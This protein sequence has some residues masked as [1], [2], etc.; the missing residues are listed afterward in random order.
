MPYRMVISPVFVLIQGCRHGRGYHIYLG[1]E[2]IF[3][4]VWLVLESLLYFAPAWRSGFLCSR[5]LQSLALPSHLQPHQVL[6]NAMAHNHQ[7]VG[8][9]HNPSPQ[10]PPSPCICLVLAQMQ[11]TVLRLRTGVQKKYLEGIACRQENLETGVVRL[12]TWEP[13]SIGYT[14]M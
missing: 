6:S 3:R 10:S 11:N 13:A 8:F 2:Y 5:H 12:R 7:I 14:Y 1:W 4:E 9:S